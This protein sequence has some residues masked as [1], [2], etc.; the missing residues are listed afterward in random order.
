MIMKMVSL[1][2]HLVTCHCQAC[3][4]ENQVTV[5]VRKSHYR[6]H[7]LALIKTNL[8]SSQSLIPPPTLSSSL[9]SFM[10][11]PEEYNHDKDLDS[12]IEDDN[13]DLDSP[14][15]YD[16]E[17]NH[18]FLYKEFGKQLLPPEFKRNFMDLAWKIRCNVSDNTYNQM[19]G[20]RDDNFWPLKK[21]KTCLRN[22]SGISSI[23]YD[24]CINGIPSLCY[25]Y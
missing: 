17:D 19:K 1:H 6:K 22:I 4:G 8:R 3:G 5:K 20:T 16:N 11:S 25:Y 10:S 21:C 14:I 9:T 23:D 12:P 18:D 24:C 2:S 15:G 13:E 7:G